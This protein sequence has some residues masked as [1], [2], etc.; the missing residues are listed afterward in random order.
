MKKIDWKKFD[1]PGMNTEKEQGFY[2]MGKEY[3][4]VAV[5]KCYITK[6]FTHTILHN[7]FTCRICCTVKVI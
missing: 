6:L 3:L 1:P 7:H 5:C 2:M 4:M